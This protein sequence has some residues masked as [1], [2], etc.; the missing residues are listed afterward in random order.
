MFSII[1]IIIYIILIYNNYTYVIPSHEIPYREQ[2]TPYHEVLTIHFPQTL[3]FIRAFPRHGRIE[4]SFIL[5]IWLTE[6]LK[7]KSGKV[8]KWKS[9]HVLK[10]FPIKPLLYGKKDLNL[11]SI[12][13]IN[14][15]GGHRYVRS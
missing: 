12:R 2:A 6:N 15:L 9:E 1:Y 5:L 14:I 8:E 10:D 11:Q 4:A 7:V 3:N 13:T